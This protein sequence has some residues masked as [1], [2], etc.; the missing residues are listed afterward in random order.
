MLHLLLENTTCINYIATTTNKELIAK[1]YFVNKGRRMI[2]M[3]CVIEDETGK[4]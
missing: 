3:E 1:G 4:N 2:V